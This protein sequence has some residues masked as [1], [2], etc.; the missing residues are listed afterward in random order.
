MA[1]SGVVVPVAAAVEEAGKGIGCGERNE[2]QRLQGSGVGVR[3]WFTPTYSAEIRRKG[4][5]MKK[6]T[7]GLIVALVLLVG[8]G[9]GAYSYFS[10]KQYVLTFSEEQIR[11]KLADKLPLTKMYFFIIQITLDNPR[12]EL[13]EGSHRINAGMDV[14]L[15]IWVGNENKS[16]GGSADVS[17][18]VAYRSETGE[19]FLVAPLVERFSVQGIPE[20]FTSRVNE[21]LGKALNEYYATHPI[22]TLKATDTKHAAA[23]LLLKDVTVQGRAVVVTLGL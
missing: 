7:L 10:G 22:Y 23:K 1:V 8:G 5:R 4:R 20:K 9:I 12:L 15:N 11:Q 13:Q 3:L 6:W 2:P 18:G 19:F 14:I 16:L 17:G 21:A